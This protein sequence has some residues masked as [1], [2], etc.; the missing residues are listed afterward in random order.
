MEE[1]KRVLSGR[2]VTLPKKTDFKEGNHVIVRMEENGSVRVVPAIVSPRQ[3]RV[4]WMGMAT[5]EET[6]TKRRKIDPQDKTEVE[7]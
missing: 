4:G 7:M 1:V 5:L 6:K 3:F 2:R